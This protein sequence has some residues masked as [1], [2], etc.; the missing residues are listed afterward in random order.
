MKF[1]PPF[2]LFYPPSPSQPNQASG[3][4]NSADME[5]GFS[6]ETPR[7]RKTPRDSNRDILNRDGLPSSRHAPYLSPQLARNWPLDAC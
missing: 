5:T 4:R 3:V 2:S 1:S 6:Q 7:Q